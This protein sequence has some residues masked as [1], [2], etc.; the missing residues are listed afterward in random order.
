MDHAFTVLSHCID[1]VDEG[2]ATRFSDGIR[3]KLERLARG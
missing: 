2:V 1:V 3:G